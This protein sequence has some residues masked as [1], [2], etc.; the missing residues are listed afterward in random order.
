[1]KCIILAAGYATRLYPLTENT[2]K[3]LLE[4]GGQSILDHI[5]KKVEKVKEVNE[6]IIVSNNRFFSQFE[7]WANRYQGKKIS[8]VNDG[9]TSNENR[10]GA[11]KDLVLVLTN[12]EIQEDIMVLAGDNL[13][14]FELFD[15]VN[16]FRNKEADCISTH[17][18]SD[19]EKIKRTGVA[20]FDKNYRVLSFEEKPD[21]PKSNYAVPP[22]YIYRKATL[23]MIKSYIT[24]G[25]NGDAPGMLVSWLLERIPLYGFHFKG[26]RYDIGT[27]ESYIEIQKHF[28]SNE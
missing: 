24:E 8:L 11:V 21:L 20:Q 23:P 22:F 25:N 7:K 9:T 19:I 2:P 16:F 18:I 15:F 12:H 1:M 5:C 4:V 13:F 14:D 26:N 28:Q 3:P 27:L 10:F 17:I 6:I